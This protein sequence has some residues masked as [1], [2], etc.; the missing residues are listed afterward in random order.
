MRK[1]SSRSSG[2]TSVNEQRNGSI[3]ETG[4]TDTAADRAKSNIRNILLASP[5]FPRLYVEMV[6]PEAPN[7]AAAKDLSREVSKK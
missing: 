4:E 7:S 2:T 1:R 6:I 3:P 5:D